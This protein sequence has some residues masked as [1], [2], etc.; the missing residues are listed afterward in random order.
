MSLTTA[1][2]A[3]VVL[4]VLYVFLKK[5]EQGEQRRPDEDRKADAMAT[6]RFHAVSIKFTPDACQAAKDLEGRRFLSSAAPRIPL[7]ECDVLE[8]HCKFV[9]HKDRRAG[10]R[11]SPFAK[12]I[13][14]DGTGSYEA[15]KRRGRDRRDDAPEDYFG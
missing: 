8:C 9:H 1:I 10:D 12:S 4:V 3:I 2:I 11:R 14:S 15:E 7:P 5:R 13:G 6:T